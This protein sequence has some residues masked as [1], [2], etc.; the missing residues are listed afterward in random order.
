MKLTKGMK[1][2]LSLL[3]AGA[4]VVTGANVDFG[5]ASA[6]GEADANTTTFSWKGE[7]YA[8]QEGADKKAV[9]KAETTE[10]NMTDAEEIG[11]KKWSAWAGGADGQWVGANFTAT[12]NLSA[13]ESAKLVVKGTADSA[14]GKV[15]L[16]KETNAAG[17]WVNSETVEVGELTEGQFV[18]EVELEAKEGQYV[19]VAPKSDDVVITNVDIIATKKASAEETNAP[20]ETTPAEVATT[21]A[22]VATTPAVTET[23]EPKET[24]TPTEAPTEAPKD[25]PAPYVY[26][27]DVADG[28]KVGFTYVSDGWAETTPFNIE[29]MESDYITEVKGDGE[30]KVSYTALTDAADIMM[31][32]LSTDVKNNTFGDDFNIVATNLK[33]GSTDYALNTDEGNLMFADGKVEDG[34]L[35]YNVR[36]PYNQK[37]YRNMIKEGESDDAY[38]V[39][40]NGDKIT[41]DN[42]LDANGD[43][44]KVEVKAGD[45]LELTFKVTG[46]EKSTATQ[47][48]TTT[49]PASQTAVSTAPAVASTKPAVATKAAV[50]GTKKITPAKKKVVVA[51]GKS[52]NVSFKTTVNAPATK[53][54]A[55]TVSSKSKKVAKVS[56]NGSK[57][58]ISV[59]KKAVKGAS[60]TITLKSV[61]ANTATGKAVS[62]KIKVYVKNATK[63]AKAAKKTVTVKKNKTAK[64]TIK[65]TAQNKKKATTDTVLKGKKVAKIKKIATVKKV[66][67]KKGKVIVTIKAKKKAGKKPLTVKLGKKKVKVNVVV[68]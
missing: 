6:A 36:N 44:A 10:E 2:A 59:P 67:A 17:E 26:P 34:C 31:A 25:T 3:L 63:K 46:S 28:F 23:E 51:A 33:V 37:V 11:A 1:K 48:P 41:C 50:E 19:A 57:V 29:E 52:V 68:K 49:Q 5:T 64:I 40:E 60:T 18:K 56:M 9:Y 43:P 7:V 27:T 61:N 39:D 15:E 32:I 42:I 30:Y 53:A 21:P 45:T 20:E 58:K 66:Q 65:V 14:A 13:Y 55:V 4:M 24:D 38:I 62:A 47:A 22:V 12:A 35:R 16:C 8:Y 54:A